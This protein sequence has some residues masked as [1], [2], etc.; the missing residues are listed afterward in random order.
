M[1]SMGSESGNFIAQVSFVFSSFEHVK[2]YAHEQEQIDCKCLGIFLEE[3]RKDDS[4]E[5]LQKAIK[6][7]PGTLQPETCNMALVWQRP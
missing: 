4:V 7:C 6:R 1:V 2:E 3:G 5:L